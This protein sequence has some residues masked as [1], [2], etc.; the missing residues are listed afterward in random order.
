MNGGEEDILEDGLRDSA[1]GLGDGTRVGQ[2]LFDYLCGSLRYLQIELAGS[3][4]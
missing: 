4:R 1:G 3:N 2:A